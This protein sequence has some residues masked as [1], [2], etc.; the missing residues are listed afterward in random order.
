MIRD[1]LDNINT[2]KNREEQPFERLRLL[3]IKRQTELEENQG[4]W[5]TQLA[6]SRQLIEQTTRIITGDVG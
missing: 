5:Q 4:T 2:N 6:K 1:Y 3:N